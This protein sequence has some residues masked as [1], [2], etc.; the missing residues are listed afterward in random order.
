MVS[1]IENDM[2]ARVCQSVSV[3]QL[4]RFLIN[5]G[6]LHTSSVERNGGNATI[7]RHA[8]L[9]DRAM[10][11]PTIGSAERMRDN[12][13]SLVMGH[14]RLDPFPRLRFPRGVLFL[15]G[16]VTLD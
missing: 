2:L 12:S 7:K 16:Y 1:A 13:F 5:L 6:G 14:K 9:S 3:E 15:N 11:K 8:P 4:E 10:R